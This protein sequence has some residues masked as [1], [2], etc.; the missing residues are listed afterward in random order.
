MHTIDVHS[1]VIYRNDFNI[2]IPQ[3]QDLTDT[4]VIISGFGRKTNAEYDRVDSWL[5]WPA[6]W[7]SLKK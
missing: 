5:S 4:C 6:L 7:F 1:S 3:T 2:A